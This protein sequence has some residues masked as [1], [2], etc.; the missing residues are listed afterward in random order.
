MIFSLTDLF[1]GQNPFAL[2]IWRVFG[3]VLMIVGRYI[4]WKVRRK[5]IEK[6]GFSHQFSTFQLK[7][8]NGHQ[9]ITNVFFQHIRHPLYFGVCLKFFGWGLFTMS[10]YGSILIMAGLTFLIPRI[11]IEETMLVKEFGDD[12]RKYQKTTNKLIPFIY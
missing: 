11:G 3:I 4:E 9:I 5:L 6:A 8:N 7:I 10:I 2:D 12:Y 1:S